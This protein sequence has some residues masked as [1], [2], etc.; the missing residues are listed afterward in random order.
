[1]FSDKTSLAILTALLRSHGVNH[2]VVCPGSRNAALVNNLTACQGIEC[3]AATDERSAAFE[4]MGISLASGNPAVVCVTSGSALLNTLPAVAEAW[5]QHVPLVVISA[6]RPAAWIDQLDGQ[7]LEQPG[8]IDRWCCS[9]VNLPEVR[10]DMERWNCNFLTNKAL[11]LAKHLN[12]PVHINVPLSEPLYNFTEKKLPEERVI[13]ERTVDELAE[14]VKRH[15]RVMVVTGQN[16]NLPSL[17]NLGFGYAVVSEPL[18]WCGT[19]ADCDSLIGEIEEPD[20]VIYLGGTIVSKRVKEFLRKT[21]NAEQWYIST[22]G[23]FADTFM[24]LANVVFVSDISCVVERLANSATAN[25]YAERWN[26]LRKH[27]V[28]CTSDEE[29]VVSRLESLVKGLDCNLCYA[30]SMSVRY[31][32]RHARHN[33]F[34]NRGVNGIEGS[35]STALGI[36]RGDGKMC[37]CVIGDLSFFYD[38]NAL[39][40]NDLPKNL[41]ILVLN[42]GGGKIFERFTA[43]QGNE[44]RRFVAGSHGATCEGICETHNVGYRLVDSLAALDNALA[45]LLSDGNVKLLEYKNKQI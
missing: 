45:W 1:M 38:C 39:W 3:H 35:L 33:I 18:A 34:C 27:V 19:W 26:E 40:R 2:A 4:A 31:A 25:Q 24:N 8:A 29:T 5:H 36:A 13:R 9:S 7:T 17:A 15:A 28:E 11:L 32:C 42:N 16:R 23:E 14:S 43:L 41:R 21:R 37:L 44:A 30:N 12:R 20:M 22:D 10:D 6:D